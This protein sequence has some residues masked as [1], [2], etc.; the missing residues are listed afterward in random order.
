MR[1]R[2]V[3]DTNVFVSSFFGGNAKR[4]IDLWIHNKITL[5][6]SPKI[7]EEY[8]RVLEHFGL[9]KEK[10][11]NEILSLFARGFNSVFAGKTP[12]LHI[13]ENDPEDNK[14]I[15]CAVALKA[16]CII[17]GDK[18]IIGIKNYMGIQ[19]LTPKQFLEFYNNESES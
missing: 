13:I 2:V 15:E 1:M 17:S 11:L 3:I 10:E 18:D 4:I 7:I 6:L 5:C 12:D 8:V 9:K 19:C 14:F 16:S